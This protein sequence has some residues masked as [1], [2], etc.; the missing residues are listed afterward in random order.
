MAPNDAR[1]KLGV[2]MCKEAQNWK[3]KPRRYDIDNMTEWNSQNY[4]MGVTY[5][6]KKLR[7]MIITSGREASTGSVT[8]NR[9][10]ES[11][12]D[13]FKSTER[14]KRKMERTGSL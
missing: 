13:L 2:E 14:Q 9:V 5:G 7:T 6:D 3:D 10:G 8:D 4:D 11:T 12:T 1:G